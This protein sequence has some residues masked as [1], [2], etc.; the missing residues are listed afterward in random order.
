[1][2]L[3]EAERERERV[4]EQSIETSPNFLSLPSCHE[5]PTSIDRAHAISL[6]FL[7]EFVRSRKTAQIAANQLRSG[8]YILAFAD[9]GKCEGATL[10]EGTTTEDGCRRRCRPPPQH[11]RDEGHRRTLCIPPAHRRSSSSSESVGS[12]R[13]P[14]VVLGSRRDHNETSD[15]FSNECSS[16]CLAL[17][18]A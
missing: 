15:A 10:T 8:A 3:R 2:F 6:N 5:T 14:C 16:S 13:L 17:P 4:R 9:E 12:V 7:F 1:M 18:S 11:V